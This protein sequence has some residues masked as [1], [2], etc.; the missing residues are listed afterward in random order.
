MSI[1][2]LNSGKLKL[3]DKDYSNAINFF[4]EAL[5]LDNTNLDAKF[6]RSLSYLDSG[7]IKEA[8]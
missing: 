8:I 7:L 4:S 6:Y 1:D 3:L 5:K 2:M